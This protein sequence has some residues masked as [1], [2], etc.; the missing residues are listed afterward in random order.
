MSNARGDEAQLLFRR[1]TTF[2]TAETAGAG[3]FMKLPFYSFNNPPRAGLEEDDAIYGDSH[4]GDAVEGLRQSGG[5]MDVP[6][7]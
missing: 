7:D 4:P 2:G 3:Q 5:T 1:Q 6:L